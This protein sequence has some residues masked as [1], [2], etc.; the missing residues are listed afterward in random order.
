MKAAGSDSWRPGVKSFVGSLML[1][2][3]GF[4]ITRGSVWTIPSMLL[5]YDN[6]KEPGEDQ[7]LMGKLPAWKGSLFE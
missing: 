5:A 7:F 1:S 3:H 6:D 2:L 4:R